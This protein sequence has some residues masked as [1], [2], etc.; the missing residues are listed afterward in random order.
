MQM[1]VSV[2]MSGISCSNPTKQHEL[3]MP[4]QPQ[5]DTDDM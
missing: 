5:K 3:V 4:H 1:T 2:G